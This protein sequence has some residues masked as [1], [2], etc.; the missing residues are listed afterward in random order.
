MDYLETDR[1]VDAKRVGIVG[2]SRLGKTVLWAGARDTRF[3]AVFAGGSGEGGA[4]L[5]RRN[6]GETVK[7]MNARFLIQFA[8]NHAK[9]D[10]PSTLPFDSHQ[11]L[12]LIAPRRCISTQPRRIAGPIRAANSWRRSRRSRST[13]Y[14]ESAD[15]I[16]ISSLPSADRSCTTSESTSVRAS[17]SRTPTTGIAI[18][19]FADL[20]LK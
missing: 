10:D 16:P 20:R 18:S 17:T 1:A 15:S 19:S 13:G 4:A 6:Y 9:Y 8:K 14:S 5:A 3:A 7:D 12:A 2:Y 11:L